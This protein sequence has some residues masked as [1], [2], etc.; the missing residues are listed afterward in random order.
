MV[1]YV[2]F[3]KKNGNAVSFEFNGNTLSKLTI[4]SE[5]EDL[6]HLLNVMEYLLDVIIGDAGKNNDS[7]KD[8]Y[9]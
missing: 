2:I 8:L 4:Q 6:D 5:C 7:D 9:N 3:R 1:V